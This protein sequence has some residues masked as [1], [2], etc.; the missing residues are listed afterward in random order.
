[1]AR[2]IGESTVGGRRFQ[3]VWHELVGR[4]MQVYRSVKL[5]QIWQ[6]LGPRPAGRPNE[7]ALAQI[8]RQA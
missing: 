2:N 8:W 7:R 4:W 1:M 6:K 5:R 3:V